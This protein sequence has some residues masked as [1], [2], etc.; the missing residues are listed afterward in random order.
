M[1][2]LCHLPLD[3][4]SSPGLLPIA[5]LPL[6][7]C[8]HNNRASSER[9]RPAAFRRPHH[10][11]FRFRDDRYYFN[12]SSRLLRRVLASSIPKNPRAGNLRPG[13]WVT[14]PLSLC[15]SFRT[16]RLS[17]FFAKDLICARS[18]HARQYLSPSDSDSVGG[19]QWYYYG[20]VE[21]R[22]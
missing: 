13:R 17:R 4:F 15:A 18:T 22:R 20:L 6:P 21:W 3:S 2:I 14:M 7:S 8:G 12:R 1:S 11:P 19:R 9:R 10:N 16:K 5:P